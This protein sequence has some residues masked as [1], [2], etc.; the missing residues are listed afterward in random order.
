MK[1]RATQTGI[2][3]HTRYERGD[4]FDIKD[5]VKK[6]DKD[7]RFLG[8]EPARDFSI[9]WMERLDGQK[10]EDPAQPTLAQKLNPFHK[11][12]EVIQ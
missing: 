1:V 6:F 4:I 2:Y 8:T 11:P 10:P 7:G 3:N 5:T 12:S 9:K